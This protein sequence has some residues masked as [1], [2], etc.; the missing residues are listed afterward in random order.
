MTTHHSPITYPLAAA[1][2]AVLGCALAVPVIA[3]PANRSAYGIALEGP[4]RSV[5]AVRYQL[6]PKERPKGGEGPK[7]RKITAGIAA[8]PKGQVVINASAF[9]EADA[10]PDAVEPFDFRIVPEDGV[11]VAADIVGLDRDRNL[12]F[13]RA[14]NPAAMLVPPITFESSPPLAIGDEVIIIG[15]LAEPYGFRHAAYATRLNGR[16]PGLRAMYSIDTTLPDL[17]AGG[18]VVRPDG[19]AVGFLGLDLLPEAWENAEPGNLLSLFGSA[20][21]GQRPG[22]QMVYPASTFVSLVAAPPPLD[23]SDKEKKGWLGITMQPLSRDLAE[24]WNIDAPGGVILDAVLE[25]SP[26]A[27]AGLKPGDVVL[28]V[29]GEPLPVREQKDL[30]VVQKMIRR[31]GAGRDVPLSIWRAGEQRTVNVKLV[32]SPTTAVT[33]EEYENDDFGVT[34]RELTY[35][36]VQSLN[37]A[38]DTHGVIVSKT[39]RAGWAQVAGLDRG[40]IVQKVDGAKITNLPTFKAALEKAHKEKRTESS[41][42]VLR[43]YKTRFVRVQTSWK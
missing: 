34:V 14:Q 30:S 28:T 24:Y 15:L 4:G 21:Q 37:L 11:E 42:L 25:G 17:C 3:E 26:A 13:I 2:L 36:V 27:A 40:D 12:A 9:P 5:V 39:E 32:A 23:E 29:D 43:N 7:V 38:N 41:L 16:A 33:A 10:G 35:D 22:Y 18:L 6:R 20:N 1:A 19:R 31:A 8:G